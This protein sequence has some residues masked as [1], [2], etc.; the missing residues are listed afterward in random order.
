MIKKIKC[1]E[2]P[3]EQMSDAKLKAIAIGII[4]A[5]SVSNALAGTPTIWRTEVNGGESLFY[6]W[7]Y[8]GPQGQT[9]AQWES[10]GTFDGAAQIQ[11]V[12]T[13]DA[14]RLTPDDMYTIKTDSSSGNPTFW[15]ANMDTQVNFYK[16]GYTTTGGSTFNNM[17]IDADGDYLIKRNDMSFN[18]YNTF[19]YQDDGSGIFAGYDFSATEGVH[20]TKIQFQPYALS[21]AKG[22]CGSVTASNP[23]ALEAM[24]GQVTFDF[25]F[26]SFLPAQP[27]DENGIG[28][29]GKG[30]MQIVSDFEMRSYGSLEIDV[31]LSDGT[32]DL[33]F[34]A[35]A[36]VNNTHPLA[37]TVELDADGNPVMIEV[38]IL[39]MDGTPALDI[40]G[41]PRTM[42][43]EKKTVGG[44][45][46][47]E[48]FYNKV[49]FMGGGVVPA[50][51]WIRVADVNADITND[52]ILEVLDA[53]DGH[54]NTIW[55]VN[56]FSGYPFLLRAD[57]VRILDAMDFS[58]Y[59]DL[60]GVP[61]SGFDADGNL[62]NLDGVIVEDLSAVPVPAS[63][64]LF[65]SGLLG[66]IGAARRKTA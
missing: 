32:T 53:D 8:G 44:G 41:N 46:T 50:G 14:D 13:T 7:G 64:W 20:N 9:A 4:S 25:G 65:S 29:P 48:G 15:D 49:S 60:S 2:F 42:M 57:G 3:I 6:D 30:G 40:H 5:L 12:I 16:W 17:Q 63:L 56:A 18:Y 23:S 22:W 52:N 33:N 58:L 19:D 66:L 38:P 51:A 36:V 28:I 55:H 35:D 21:D 45:G 37:S 27:H 1:K 59:N 47:D 31:T 61:A 34:Y 54:E 26:E 43:K 62:I 11:H 10:N 24:A 39:N